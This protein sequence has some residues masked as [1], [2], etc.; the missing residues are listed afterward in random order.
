[1]L[2]S[3]NALWSFFFLGGFENLFDFYIKMLPHP[4]IPRK[5]KKKQE[6]FSRNIVLRGASVEFFYFFMFCLK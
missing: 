5:K 2:F 4:N 3:S 1:M 6:F